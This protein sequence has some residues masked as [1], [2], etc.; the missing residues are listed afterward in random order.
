MSWPAHGR[1]CESIGGAKHGTIDQARAFP[2]M[3]G[4][5]AYN[6]RRTRR[7]LPAPRAL[8]P[9]ESLQ[10]LCEEALADSRGIALHWD[11]TWLLLGTPRECV[12]Q[13]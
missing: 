2:D 9:F 3:P 4:G 13:G 8:A 11:D 12:C 5:L 10:R 7:T 6:W 1:Q